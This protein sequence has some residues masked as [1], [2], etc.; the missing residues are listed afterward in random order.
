LLL[1]KILIVATLAACASAACSTNESGDVATT[2]VGDLSYAL[3]VSERTSALEGPSAACPS[4]G[5]EDRSGAVHRRPYLQQVTDRSAALLWTAGPEMKA[6]M[7]TA[8]RSDGTVMATAQGAPDLTVPKLTAIGPSAPELPSLDARAV[9][10][11]ADL[12]QLEPDTSY[13]FELLSE[14]V[15]LRRGSF[16]TA[17][18]AGAGRPVRFVALGDSG[19]GGSDQ[20]AVFEQMLQVPFDLV[21]HTGDI[22]YTSGTRAQF[23][24]VFFDMYADMLERF[25]VFPASGNHEYET[26]DAAP[27]REVFALP[28]NGGP[29]GIERWYSYDWG[30]V[31]F[32][33]LDT[34]R[35]S[36][37]QAAWL[38]ADLTANRRPWTIVYQHRPAFSSG[39]HGGDPD[40]QKWFVPIFIK[41]HVPLVLAGHDHHYERTNAID[42]VT[43]V[44]TG[45]GG[46]GTRPVG[47]SDFTAF[48]EQVCHFVYVTINGDQLT[49]HAIDGTG[50]EFDSLRITR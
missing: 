23:E 2:N 27:F 17:P 22:A 7:V 35:T 5:A 10:W 11:R 45:G 21:L 41:H 3:P 39:D 50:E 34:E 16:R 20:Q 24:R 13:C 6:A 12:A 42:G 37:E 46:R 32:V 36:A 28:E 29:A 14:G 40:V 15:V 47:Q 49:L 31:H 19:E 4:A 43:Y 48:S 38:D 8:T 33:V 9:Q 30:D 18:L 1:K 44:V 25:P 26:E